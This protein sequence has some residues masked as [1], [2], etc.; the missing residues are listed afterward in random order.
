MRIEDVVS[1]ALE[2]LCYHALIDT[3][4]S[5]DGAAD[6]LGGAPEHLISYLKEKG[7]IIMASPDVKPMEIEQITNAMAKHLNEVDG[8]NV[9]A[10]YEG[11]QNWPNPDHRGYNIG[12]DGILELGKLAQ[13]VIDTISKLEPSPDVPQQTESENHD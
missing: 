8:S 2:D 10:E 7:F 4:P 6:V 9:F 13:V 1:E 3:I 5:N 11:Y 12:Y